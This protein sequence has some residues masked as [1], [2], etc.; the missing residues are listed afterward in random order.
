MHAHA[1]HVSFGQDCTCHMPDFGVYRIVAVQIA[2]KVKY[3]IRQFSACKRLAETAKLKF[4]YIKIFCIKLSKT[5]RKATA[6]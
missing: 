2:E 3:H 4:S 1:V 6:G 5:Y